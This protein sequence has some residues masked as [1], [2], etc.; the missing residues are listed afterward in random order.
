[1]LRAQF[2]F[3]CLHR[4]TGV[5]SLFQGQV[6]FLQEVLDCISVDDAFNNLIMKVI[7]EAVII[8]EVAGLGQFTA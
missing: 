7:L 5:N 3:C 1:M 8:T 4:P 6:M 2:P